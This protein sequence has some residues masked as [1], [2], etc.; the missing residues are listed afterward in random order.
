MALP[1]GTIKRVKPFAF[2]EIKT[3]IMPVTGRNA[4]SSASSPKKTMPSVSA[5][6]WSLAFKI[7]IASGK[8]KCEPSF[9]ISAGARF[10][11][12]LFTGKYSALFFMADSTLSLLSLTDAEGKPTKS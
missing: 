1:A 8:S 11:V 12:I 5:V 3:G 6:S 9:F 7:L 2:A 10:M 4:P